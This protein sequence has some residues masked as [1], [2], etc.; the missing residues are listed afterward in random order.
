MAKVLI[1]EDEKALSDAYRMILEKEKHTVTVAFDGKE[2]LESVKVFTPDI[3]LLDLLMPKMN[4]LEFLKHF[5]PEEHKNTKVIVLTNL[6]TD[7]E[8][9][10]AR[11]LGA[12]RYIVKARLAPAELA[13]LVNHIVRKNTPKKKRTS[14]T[15]K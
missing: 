15:K 3:I 5:K 13:V 8:V 11:E 4:G 9:K 7:K 12:S 6:D 14:S 1:V 2:A 10:G